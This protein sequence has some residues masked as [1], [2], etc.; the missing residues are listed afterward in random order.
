MLLNLGGSLAGKYK[1]KLFF[2]LRTPSRLQVLKSATGLLDID[3]HYLLLE[4][5]RK[6]GIQKNPSRGSEKLLE[7]FEQRKIQELGQCGVPE[8]S[9]V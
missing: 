4:E 8:R 6:Q 1:L 3:Y 9:Q 2:L 5:H 7:D